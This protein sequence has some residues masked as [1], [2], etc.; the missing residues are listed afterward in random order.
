MR[1]RLDKVW[2]MPERTD[3]REQGR[4]GF[5]VYVQCSTWNILCRS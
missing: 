3:F 5:Q 4:S 1:V 2:K